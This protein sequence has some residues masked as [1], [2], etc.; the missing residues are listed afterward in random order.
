MA[1]MP[2]GN[3]APRMLRPTLKASNALAKRLHS[4]NVDRRI[5][6]LLLPVWQANCS[7]FVLAVPLLMD[8]PDA[9]LIEFPPMTSS[10]LTPERRRALEVLASSRH[11]VNAELLVHGYG[12][13]RR[14]LAGLVRAGLAAAKRE[15]VMAGCK[16]VELVRLRITAAGRRAIKAG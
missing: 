14:V 3:I 6:A 15:V 1:L 4:G 7:L 13:S 10:R 16:A 11:G 8:V 2:K 5:H 12:F 9:A